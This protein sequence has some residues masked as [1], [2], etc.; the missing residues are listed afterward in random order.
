MIWLKSG[1]RGEHFMEITIRRNND[2]NNNSCNNI[3]NNNPIKVACPQ[4]LVNFEQTQAIFK[5]RAQQ[6]FRTLIE[7]KRDKDRPRKTSKVGTIKGGT[8][9]ATG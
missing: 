8:F 1:A 2:N 6:A 4:A 9:S 7:E 3:Y 5:H